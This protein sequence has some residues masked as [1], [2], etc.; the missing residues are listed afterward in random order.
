MFLYSFLYLN[1]LTAQKRHKGTTFFW[2]TQTKLQKD[3]I[4]TSKVQYNGAYF[5]F[6]KLII[7]KFQKKILT[8]RRFF[9]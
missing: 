5:I 6:I 4:V 1:S 2:I 7:W 3:E 9:V 8:L